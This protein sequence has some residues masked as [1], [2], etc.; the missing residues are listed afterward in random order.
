M[1]DEQV[2]IPEDL[3]RLY[4]LCEFP[5]MVGMD[6]AW[7]LEAKALIERIARAE[8]ALAVLETQW[9]VRLGKFRMALDNLLQEHFEDK[10]GKWEELLTQLNASQQQVAA[11]EA[12]NA[13]L[14]FLSP[15]FL[16]AMNDIGR[17]GF[18]KY[19]EQSFQARRLK[20]D[21][22]RGDMKRT[23]PQ[24]IADHAREHFS[25]YLNHIPHDHFG[26]D[27]HQLA[28]VAFNAMMEFYFAA[29]KGAS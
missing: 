15:G 28:A 7:R 23:T 6:S 27:A 19:G 18:E 13:E 29:L 26:T 5:T 9:W 12:R 8:Q 11:L 20:G 25:M 1:S 16:R 10:A 4:S 14:E 17:Y 24:A 3:R 21:T 2:K 22:S